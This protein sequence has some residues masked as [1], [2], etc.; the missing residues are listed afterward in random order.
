MERDDCCG[1]AEPH[2]GHWRHTRLEH[3]TVTCWCDG[4]HP[5]TAQMNTILAGT[6]GAGPLTPAT[7]DRLADLLTA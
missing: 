5:R 4:G 1:R 2:P 3:A 6:I 7:L